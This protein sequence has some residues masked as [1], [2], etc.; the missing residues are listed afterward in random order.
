M[1]LIGV[2][3]GCFIMGNNSGASNEKPEHN[4]CVDTFYMAETELT[5]AQY[6]KA[7]GRTSKNTGHPTYPA[8]NIAPIDAIS[9]ITEI[10]TKTGKNY[11]LPTEA[12]WEF[13]ASNRGGTI[14]LSSPSTIAWYQ[15]NSSGVV[16]SVKTRA[17]NPLGIYDLFG[18]VEE[19]V[20]DVY[21]STY[22]ITGNP[23]SNPTGPLPSANPVNDGYISRGG[24]FNST[25]TNLTPTKRVITGST[26]PT[27][28]RGIRLVLNGPN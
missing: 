22:T 21:E 15:S 16:H 10:R 3:G 12:E 4:V 18:N 25:A 2:A 7:T 26:H 6:E 24:H 27:A 9:L 17:A 20:N 11:R 13:A 1:K 19:I 28:T 8:V 23:M 14:D 5:E